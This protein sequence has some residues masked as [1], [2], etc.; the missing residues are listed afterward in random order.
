[1]R[2]L[3]RMNSDTVAVQH[4]FTN[5]WVNFPNRA[6]GLLMWVMVCVLS[7]CV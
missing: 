6:M 5:V 2:W 3:T 4:W 7:T 1:M